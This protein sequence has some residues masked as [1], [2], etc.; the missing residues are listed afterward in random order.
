MKILVVED[1]SANALLVMKLLKANSYEALL[2]TN[3]SEALELIESQYFDL[4]ILDWNL[5]QKSGILL[6]EELRSMEI[7]SQVIMLSANSDVEYRV[8]ALDKGADD[9]LCKPYS[10]LE[11]LARVNSLLRRKTESKN[12]VVNIG[13]L[14]IDREKNSV[15][16][17]GKSIDLTS[18]EYKVL[19]EL[20]FNPNKIFT[21][22][23]LFDLLHSDYSAT[24]MSNIVEVH[25]K[26][27]RKKVNDKSVIKT[28]RGV[29]Y[30]IR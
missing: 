3:Y 8:K 26:N 11:L 13:N 16:L 15:T 18:A 1:D 21:K 9:Y 25:I 7:N 22:H 2:A 30:K 28:V 5:P 17:E 14:Q 6:L 27:I 20:A 10:H 19:S 29:G 24:H 23:E 4:I 12:S